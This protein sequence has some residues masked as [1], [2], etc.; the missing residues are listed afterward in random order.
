[1]PIL[2]TFTDQSAKKRLD[3]L[4]AQHIIKDKKIIFYHYILGNTHADIE[5]LF[6]TA[7]YLA[8]FNGA[9]GKAITVSEIDISKPLIPQLKKKNDGKD[10]NHYAPANFF[11]KNVT[12]ITLSDD[13]LDNFEK[14][15]VKLNKLF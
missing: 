6:A 13:T 4:V 2:D 12:S 8:L 15:F 14:L 7:D 10:F 5:D 1:M 11:A 9:L 3:N